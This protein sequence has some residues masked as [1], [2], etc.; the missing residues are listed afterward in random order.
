MFVTNSIKFLNSFLLSYKCN[1]I[2]DKK[3]KVFEKQHNL[4]HN[5]RNIKQ[6]QNY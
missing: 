4:Q 6:V 3:A 1:I 5:T 2:C